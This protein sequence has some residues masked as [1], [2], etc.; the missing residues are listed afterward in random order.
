M[1]SQYYPIV[2]ISLHSSLDA[3]K[4]IQI[5]QALQPLLQKQNKSND[6]D[7]NNDI[8]LIGSGYT[9]H[10]MNSFFNPSTETYKQSELFNKWLKET[11][12]H[13]TSFNERL[14][15]LQ[16]W[17]QLTT[18]YG[19]QCHPRE[20]HFLPLL[21]LAAAAGPNAKPILSYNVDSDNTISNSTNKKQQQQHAV[22][23]YSFE[24]T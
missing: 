10:N 24:M 14:D 19:R 5:G 20:E 1:Q 23:S 12:L 22:S 4:H 16:S 13:S 18:P 2:C 17:E 7:Y 6:N 3:T 11:M 15:K 9:F 21:V 8:L